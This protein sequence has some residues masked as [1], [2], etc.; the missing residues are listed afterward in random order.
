M[1]PVRFRIHDAYRNVYIRNPIVGE[2]G[3]IVIRRSIPGLFTGM[4]NDKDGSIYREKYFSK[5]Q[6]IFALSDFGIQNSFTMNWIIV[7]RSD[8]TLK[9]R[10]CR[11]GSSEIYN[12][13]EEFP[14]IRDSLCVS[15]YNKDLDERAVLFLKIRDG[16][17]FNE[18]LVA[19]IRKAIEKALTVRHVPDVILEIKDIPVCTFIFLLS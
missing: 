6:G 2:I 1:H 13:V 4:W 10:G 18:E 14:E 9:Q 11:F 17:K 15:Q 16:Y 19:K 8:E 12:I 5:Y 3:E 7:C